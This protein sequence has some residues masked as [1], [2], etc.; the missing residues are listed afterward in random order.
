[1]ANEVD[2]LVLSRPTKRNFV[3]RANAAANHA[4]KQNQI[5]HL[6]KNDDRSGTSHV[7]D[8]TLIVHEAHLK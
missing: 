4:P 2:R 8:P 7:A 3:R 5:R 1:M 6:T